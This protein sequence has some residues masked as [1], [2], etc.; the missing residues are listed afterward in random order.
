M[1]G[2]ERNNY[3]GSQCWSSQKEIFGLWECS[4]RSFKITKSWSLPELLFS[5]FLCLLDLQFS[6][7]NFV[8]QQVCKRWEFWTEQGCPVT[9]EL[10]SQTMSSALSLLSWWQSYLK[11]V[12]IIPGTSQI[13][14][15]LFFC[16]TWLCPLLAS[17]VP[18]DPHG[19]RKTLKHPCLCVLCSATAANISM[20]SPQIPLKVQNSIIQVHTKKI[21]Y[22]LVK[23]MTSPLEWLQVAPEGIQ[24]VY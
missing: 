8:C 21:N 4:S 20:L 22:I 1:G 10:L 16:Y 12:E 9:K 7:N 18:P 3:S 2:R 11:M 23:T 5:I 24:V 19:P 15:S 17:C 6:E 14:C 13:K